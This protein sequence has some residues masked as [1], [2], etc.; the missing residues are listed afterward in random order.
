MIILLACCLPACGSY[1]QNQCEDI[2]GEYA[3]AKTV[4]SVACKMS[5]KGIKVQNRSGVLPTRS[6]LSI[7][8]GSCGLTAFEDIGS[9]LRI[10]YYGTM[11]ND[12]FTLQIQNPSELAIP[13]ELKIA[14]VKHKCSFNGSIVW[15]GS[16]SGD[17]LEGGITYDLDK[18]SD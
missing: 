3:V 1:N 14:G 6:I 9:G 5:G 12:K 10:P 16:Q 7:S 2:G 15:D 8:Q 17:G 13:L 11:D 18:R 4:N